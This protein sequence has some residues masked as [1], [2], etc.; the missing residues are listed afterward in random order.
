MNK[1]ELQDIELN[2]E[3]K[4]QQQVINMLNNG[5]FKDLKDTEK[6]EF[7]IKCKASGLNPFSRECYALPFNKPNGDKSIALVASYDYLINK[8][9]AN[10]IN[11]YKEPFIIE[12]K[13]LWVTKEKTIEVTDSQVIKCGQIKSKDAEDIFCEVSIKLMNDKVINKCSGNYKV[14]AKGLFQFWEKDLA[15][16]LRKC[17]TLKALRGYGLLSGEPYAK[18]E[19]VGSSPISEEKPVAEP[20]R[21]ETLVLG[22]IEEKVKENEN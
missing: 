22:A 16:M 9:R 15:L 21:N 19:M 20:V 7:A 6:V 4:W 13:F 10:F 2:Q 8:A 12:T 11:D 3:E 18:E 1:Q 5:G 17:C 14:W